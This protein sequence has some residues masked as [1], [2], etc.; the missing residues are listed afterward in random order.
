MVRGE[1]LFELFI[2]VLARL[3]CGRNKSFDETCRNSFALNFT[4]CKY[5]N[6]DRSSCILVFASQCCRLE[7]GSELSH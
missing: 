3:S 1:T 2:D 6:R 4:T 5:A 7:P